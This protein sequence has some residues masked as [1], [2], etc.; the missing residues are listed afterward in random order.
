MRVRA[1]EWRLFLPSDCASVVSAARL[2]V[3]VLWAL[4]EIS[5][6]ELVALR[7]ECSEK[8]LSELLGY[9]AYFSVP[10]TFPRS[11]FLFPTPHTDME[12]RVSYRSPIKEV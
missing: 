2:S 3:G 11:M 6:Q 4:E 12:I 8:Y 7:K 1:K 5:W 9:P 10:A